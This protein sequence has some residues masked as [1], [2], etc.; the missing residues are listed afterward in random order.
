MWS[1]YQM[2]AR[3][4][5]WTHDLLCL[6]PGR[7]QSQE[8]AAGF[9]KMVCTWAQ[10][11]EK[12]EEDDSGNQPQPPDSALRCASVPWFCVVIKKNDF[13]IFS[14]FSIYPDLMPEFECSWS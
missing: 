7:G 13:Y 5:K 12:I 3:A 14:Y 9:L 1:R 6:C 11:M 2:E 8:S 4:V 10:C